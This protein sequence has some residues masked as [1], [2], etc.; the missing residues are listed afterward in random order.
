[1]R[2]LC[3][4]AAE[5]I[6]VVNRP[7]FYCPT[8][9]TRGNYFVVGPIGTT[10]FFLT[11]TTNVLHIES[12]DWLFITIVHLLTKYEFDVLNMSFVF[13]S[14]R[15]RWQR[16]YVI[17]QNHMDK[18]VYIVTL[19]EPREKSSAS[20]HS[21]QRTILHK[22]VWVVFWAELGRSTNSPRFFRWWHC[23]FTEA[24]TYNN[25]GAWCHHYRTLCWFIILHLLCTRA[26]SFLLCMYV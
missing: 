15:K 25:Y 26:F 16:R 4:H 14:Y 18:G 24:F 8:F 6:N 19:S 12:V 21:K 13:F 10:A 11:M 9:S 2:H 7:C 3:Q 23:A 20:K 22:A 1:M 17:K 5:K